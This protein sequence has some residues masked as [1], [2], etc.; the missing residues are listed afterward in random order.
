M[1]NKFLTL[2]FP[3]ILLIIASFYVTSQFIQPAPKK[4]LV[5]ATGSK[6]GNYYTTAL[7]YQA[8]LK[9]EGIEVKILNSAGSVE[10]LSLLKEKK[11]DI[12][13]VQNGIAG[14][15]HNVELLA[16]VYYEPLWIFYK[17]DSYTMD[18]VIQLI[19]KTIAVGQQ[20]SGTDHLSQMILKDNGITKENSTIV[21]MSTTQGKEKLIKGEIDALFA[22]SAASSSVIQELLENPSVNVL[23]IKRAKAYSRK[24]SFLEALTLYE[25]TIDLYKNLPDEDVSLLAT[26]AD[27]VANQ[28]VPEELIRILM[29]KVQFIHSQ[30][31]LFA[32]DN[33]FPNTSNTNLIINEEATKYL[34][35]GDSFLEKIFPYWIASNIDRLKILLIPI[36]T[37]MF[38]L[39]KGVLPLYQWTMRSKIYRWYDQVN[40]IDQQIPTMNQEERLQTLQDLDQLKIDI[41]TVTKVPLSFM[42][43]YYNLIM[44]IDM[45][46]NKLEKSQTAS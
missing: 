15:E 25:G 42:G 44:H 14:N 17:N 12:A 1:K 31:T 43:E 21:N 32:Q 16:S 34:K 5:I 41:Q 19:G 38:P 20:K 36:L 6:N 3:A 33:H 39:F 45:I 27:L 18:Y 4:E 9:E 46:R 10:N 11:A 22:V 7:A 30:K 35:N 37:L 26:T 40:E 28:G 29:K 8:L 2:G 23:S 13:F 24:Y